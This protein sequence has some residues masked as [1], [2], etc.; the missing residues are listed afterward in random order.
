MEMP[1]L[2]D[3]TDDPLAPQ[4]GLSA[5]FAPLRHIRDLPTVVLVVLTRVLAGFPLDIAITGVQLA[6]DEVSAG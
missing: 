2:R 6:P 1:P 4:Y 5:D 3:S